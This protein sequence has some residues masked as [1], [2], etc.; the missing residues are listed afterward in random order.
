MERSIPLTTPS[1]SSSHIDARSF[2]IP[3][4]KVEPPEL[5]KLVWPELDRYI[6][7]RDVEQLDPAKPI[8]GHQLCHA[9][10]GFTNLLEQPRR[11][12]LQDSAILRP[13]FP[14]HPIWADEVF[15]HPLYTSFAERVRFEHA[16]SPESTRE[17]QLA[18]AVPAIATQLQTLRQEHGYQLASL[19]RSID[20]AQ[21]SIDRTQELILNNQRAAIAMAFGGGLAP[22]VPPNPAVADDLVRPAPPL[23][24]SG[25][26]NPHEP[27]SHHRCKA[28]YGVVYRPRR[29]ALR[30][31][32]GPPVRHKV[33]ERE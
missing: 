22:A 4:D 30:G 16:N 24:S 32:D 31:A 21:Q 23:A 7:I 26:T 33:A 5:L 27:A 8:P 10:A 9:G 13:M 2:Y 19:Q 18:A 15:R 25:V 12:L 29:Q 14:N 3:R 6:R 1:P 11:Y 17:Q 28:L 20:N